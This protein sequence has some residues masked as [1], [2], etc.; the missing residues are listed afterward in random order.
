MMSSRGDFDGAIAPVFEGGERRPP[1]S[2]EFTE[3]SRQLIFNNR[4]G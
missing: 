1:N 3:Y 4:Q 2:F